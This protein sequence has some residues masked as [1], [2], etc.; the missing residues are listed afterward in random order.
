M[1]H[2]SL[3]RKIVFDKRKYPNRSDLTLY[4]EKWD[5]L[6]I[7][8][9]IDLYDTEIQ[10]SLLSIKKFVSQYYI[11]KVPLLVLHC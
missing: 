7:Y 10:D 1:S 3:N 6:R 8:H 11:I 9:P 5:D 2:M 4:N